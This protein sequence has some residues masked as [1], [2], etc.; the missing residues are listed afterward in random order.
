[1]KN[2]IALSAMVLGL[3]L[4]AGWEPGFQK[5]L[6][7]RPCGLV[8]Q[9]VNN[10]YGISQLKFS[11]SKV[12]KLRDEDGEP[13]KLNKLF[14]LD[15]LDCA[16]FVITKVRIKGNQ[17][18][19]ENGQLKLLFNGHQVG[20]TKKIKHKGKVD[21][22]HAWDLQEAVGAVFRPDDLTE[23]VVRFTGNYKAKKTMN[24]A[25]VEVE[26]EYSPLFLPDFGYVDHYT[27]NSVQVG[28]GNPVIVNNSGDNNVFNI[29]VV[30]QNV[31]VD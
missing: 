20:G 17:T 21:Y 18:D 27:P 2:L 5:G 9:K 15:R 7:P 22:P 31:F 13:I 16:N 6:D 24:L 23:I 12:M 29:T 8:G 3:N 30:N 25:S 11:N 14:A 19:S 10:R 26:W 4:Y 1:M 28:G